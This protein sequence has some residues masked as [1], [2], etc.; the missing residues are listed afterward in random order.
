MKLRTALRLADGDIVAFVG[1]G[2]K[3]SAMFRLADEIVESGGRVVTSTTT[4]MGADQ[5]R[6]APEHF[7][8]FEASRA[9]VEAA[10]D[11]RAHVLVTG[12]VD[13]TLHKAAAVTDGLIEDLHAIPNLAAILV[14]ADGA[15]LLPF[16]APAGHE[17]AIPGVATL[18]VPI[19]GMEVLGQ[20]LDPEH[21]HRPERIAALAGAEPGATITPEIVARV[22]AH[23]Q[24]GLKNVPDGA[25]VCV[26]LNKV[27][28]PEALAAAREIAARVLEQASIESILIGS[29]RR[30]SPITGVHGRVAAIVL[31]AGQSKRMGRPKQ[32]MPWG[33]TTLLGEVVRR[34]QR[35]SV[36]DIVIVTG[37][38]REAVE[39]LLAEP[40][41][42]DARV[43]CVFNPDYAEGEMARS[44]QIGLRALPGNRL[45]ALVALADQPQIEPRVVE[46]VLQ[47]WRETQAPAV[48]PF[49]GEQRGHPLLFDRAL[50]PTLMSLPMEANPRAAVS[51]A[52]PIERVNVDTDSV[53]RDI[54]TPEDYE[55]AREKS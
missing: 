25:R 7:S 1:A 9:N 26:L 39:A 21:A 29:T 19:V 6:R 11:G 37:A 13:R 22:L 40:M 51:A 33:A 15:R 18:V 54:D 42:S 5:I 36:S 43:H 3:T 17:P 53:L 23:P 12:P 20:P 35:T 48:A 16:K 47:R 55:R 14:E 38:D 2:G 34:L 45:A 52:G 41:N 46:A 4:H 24:G 49:F 27:E 31:A 28:S 10:L 50:W 8:A 30:D 44:L 32:L